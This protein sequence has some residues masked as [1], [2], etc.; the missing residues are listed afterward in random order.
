MLLLKGPVPDTEFDDR[1]VQIRGGVEAA[2]ADVGEILPAVAALK[3]RFVID[4]ICRRALINNKYAV[5]DERGT[6]TAEHVQ[7]VP[8]L[9]EIIQAVVEQQ[10]GVEAL[11]EVKVGKIGRLEVNV[12]L[13][14]V[15][16][17][18]SHLQHRLGPVRGDIAIAATRLQ[19]E[20]ERSRAAA[21][22]EQRSS[23]RSMPFEEFLYVRRPGFV[24]NVRHYEIV[25]RR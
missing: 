14:L 21:E 11:A 24:V 3:I 10:H 13:R 5:V 12:C 22:L 2:A 8:F 25:A 1:A 6:R 18:A 15:G 9:E 17:A 20:R 19:Q 7:D 16:F 4:G 23:L